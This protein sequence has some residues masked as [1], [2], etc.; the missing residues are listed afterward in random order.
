MST[1]P[2]RHKPLPDSPEVLRILLDDATRAVEHFA[3]LIVL[4]EALFEA[5]EADPPD[6]ALIERHHRRLRDAMAGAP[7]P[8]RNIADYLPW[9]FEDAEPLRIDVYRR[10][11]TEVVARSGG[12]GTNQVGEFA[13]VYDRLRR[14]IMAKLAGEPEEPETPETPACPV[15]LLGKDKGPLVMGVEQPPLSPS[16]YPVIEALAGV[17]PQRIGLAKLRGEVRRITG[18][19]SAGSPHKRLEELQVLPGTLWPYVIARPGLHMRNGYGFAWPAD[20]HLAV[21][22]PASPQPAT[23]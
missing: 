8:T 23:T 3:R 14:R 15:R 10:W 21:V 12:R 4:G 5:A 7:P 16:Q 6:I 18:R 9:P 2:A 13:R 17:Y 19:R 1:P 22:R 20:P 11:M